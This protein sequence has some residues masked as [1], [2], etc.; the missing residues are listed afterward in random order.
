[1][2]ESRVV[3]WQQ[4]STTAFFLCASRIPKLHRMASS[5][6]GIPHWT[7][8][9]WRGEVQQHQRSKTRQI[10]RWSTCQPSARATNG[11]GTSLVPGYR[12][13]QTYWRFLT[14]EDVRRFLSHGQFHQQF[15]MLI[16]CNTLNDKFLQRFT[17]NFRNCWNRVDQ[18]NVTWKSFS[19]TCVCHLAFNSNAPPS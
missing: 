4:R 15:K 16:P 8:K 9:K 11:N 7:S 14:Y 1:M 17:K 10:L 3:V 2:L 19:A 13:H 18:D 5:D 12:V 6:T